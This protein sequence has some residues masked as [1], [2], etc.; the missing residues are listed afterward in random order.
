MI[1][2]GSRGATAHFEDVLDQC[3][4]SGVR[5]GPDI[6]EEGE[7]VDMDMSFHW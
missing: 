3:M 1:A 6:V 5:V 2:P 7:G 4:N